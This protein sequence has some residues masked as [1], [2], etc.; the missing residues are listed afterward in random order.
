[1]SAHTHTH[2]HTETC[3]WMHSRM[4]KP[5]TLQ[6]SAL[7]PVNMQSIS[8]ILRHALLNRIIHW[9]RIPMFLFDHN[10][11]PVFLK[12]QNNV[13]VYF[14]SITNT[15]NLAVSDYKTDKWTKWGHTLNHWQMSHIPSAFMIHSTLMYIVTVGK[16]TQTTWTWSFVKAQH[17]DVHSN[18][19][20]V[21][22]NHMDLEF[23]QSTAHWCT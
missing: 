18:S 1:M 21:Y 20:Q 17:I 12:I 15:N 5:D 2:A 10:H 14:L 22:T 13:H 11:K 19:Q 3:I 6:C 7:H 16:S 4:W 9:P 23:C 8:G